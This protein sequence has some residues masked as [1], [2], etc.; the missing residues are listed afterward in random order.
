MFYVLVKQI[1]M[2]NEKEE[3]INKRLR[4]GGLLVYGLCRKQI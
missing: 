1:M 2:I 4:G 3:E